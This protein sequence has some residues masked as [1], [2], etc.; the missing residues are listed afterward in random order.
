VATSSID[1]WSAEEFGDTRIGDVRRGRRLVRIASM[2]ARCPAG[3][4]AATFATGAEREAAYRLIGRGS[5][6]WQALME[7]A[8]RAA[9]RRCAAHETVIVPVDGSSLSL[10][11]PSSRR[12]LGPV[13]TRS[14]GALGVLLMTALALDPSGTPLGLLDQHYWT[15]SHEPPARPT[16][17]RGSKNNHRPREE[18]ESFLWVEALRRVTK[19]MSS[20]APKC[21]PHFQM[22]RGAD[23]MSV[24][25]EA[26][27]AN[28][29][30][31]VR[32]VHD[33]C[34]RWPNGRDGYLLTSL[35][36]RPV[37]GQY[38]VEV[39]KRATQLERTATMDLRV[40]RM[41][42]VL[43]LTK[44]K[45][46]VLDATVVLATER[47]PPRGQAPLRW[48]LFTTAPVKNIADAVAVVAGY[49][50]RW[51]IEDFFKTWKSG[52]C[53][54]ET[55]K[56]Q[57]KDA[58]LRWATIMA[59]VAARIESLRH[60][61]R[62]T[63]NA[64]ATDHFSRDEIDASILLYKAGLTKLYVPYDRGDTPTVAEMAHWIASLGGHMGNPKTR[65]PGATVL[66]RGLERVTTA[67]VAL[68][69]A[70]SD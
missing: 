43:R 35:R 69:A 7:S 66:T 55:S 62:Q 17:R 23:C 68:A 45:R 8:A 57:T 34:L 29:R 6:S 15:R 22:D 64:P 50:R 1:K 4:V 3:T 41:P 33:R 38:Q 16:R 30:V 48:M 42:L 40:A 13:G 60:A 9:A 47:R 5:C 65:P 2:A 53:N 52:A 25:M 46:R 51:R 36:S 26:A 54:V 37:L 63:P 67:A 10:R 70:R 24:L 39:S 28:L 12:G 20:L 18:R 19:R 32:A 27:D 11:D 58:I 44:T 56:L 59:S 31:T 21:T 14:Q 61:A 49:T